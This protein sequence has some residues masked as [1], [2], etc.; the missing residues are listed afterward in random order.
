M[1]IKSLGIFLLFL[2][3]ACSTTK[4]FPVSQVAPAAEITVKQKTDNNDNN[5]ITVKA[6]YLA[7]PDRVSR[8]ATAYVVWLVSEENGIKNIGALYNENGEDSE[9]ETVTSFIGTEI[10]ITAER[11]AG[12]SRPDGVEISRVKL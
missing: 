9:L 7:S 8:G 5:Q 2:F 10:F 1:K 4:T 6:K 12:I 11:E 3:T